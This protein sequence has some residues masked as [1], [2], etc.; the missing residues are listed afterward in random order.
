MSKIITFG[1]RIQHAISITDN[2][3]LRLLYQALTIL[4]IWFIYQFS[5][6]G[7]FLIIKG[8]NLPIWLEAIVLLVGV[9]ILLFLADFCW[10]YIHS[11]ELNDQLEHTYD[12]E[13]NGKVYATYFA[14]LVGLALASNAL[15]SS[16]GSSIGITIGDTSKNQ[17]VLQTLMAQDWSS[18]IYMT[19]VILLVAPMIEEFTFR[20]MFISG[21]SKARPIR[22]II[23]VLIFA[24]AH[25]GMQLN[26][27]T[28]GTNGVLT[29][30]SGI[31]MYLLVSLTL[32]IIYYKY[33]R[34]KASL[35][36]HILWN[37]L[38]VLGMYALLL[39]N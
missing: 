1:S 5:E 16:I 12:K 29:F 21:Y 27:L 10:S 36:V 34:V 37:S 20:F 32:T 13:L 11:Q 4:G 19:V 35:T 23:S 26:Q 33:H 31:T 39:A 28:K 3:Y 6:A 2:K 22:A 24:F 14:A 30:I 17:N 9:L 25:M 38:S 7:Y 18:I 8:H 15:I